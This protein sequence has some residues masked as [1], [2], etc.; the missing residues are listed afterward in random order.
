MPQSLAATYI[1]LV[2]A[3]KER[4]P[5]FRDL[6]LRTELHRQLGAISK[7]LECQP[8]LTGGVEDHIHQL[9]SLGRTVTIANWVKELKRVS[10][11]WIT[12]HG[13]EYGT[14]EWQGG[15]AAFSVSHSKLALITNYIARQE[16][17][18]RKTNFQNELRNRLRKHEVEWDERYVWD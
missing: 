4:R 18:H 7:N 6:A 11:L 9:A 5:W 12:G 14:F 15:Y 2:F 3:T 17:H 13:R 1:H 8:I 10:N 16:E